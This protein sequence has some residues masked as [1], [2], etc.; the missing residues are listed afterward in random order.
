[1]SWHVWESARW[2][3]EESFPGRGNSMCKIGAP[4][5]SKEARVAGAKEA[6]GQWEV[7]ADVGQELGLK[8]TV[9]MV[10]TG[11]LA[12]KTMGALG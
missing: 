12:L 3:V 5:R 10:G 8:A 2:L 6:E 11:Q 4:R 9:M 7:R 1:M